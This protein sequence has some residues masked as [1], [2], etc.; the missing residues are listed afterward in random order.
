MTFTSL[1]VQLLLAVKWHLGLLEYELASAAMRGSLQRLQSQSI[2]GTGTLA[3]RPH[4]QSWCNWQLLDISLSFSLSFFI[5]SVS[6]LCQSFSLPPEEF[7]S[8]FLPILMC[9]LC[10]TY[11]TQKK[12]TFLMQI[13]VHLLVGLTNI[14][15]SAPGMK[16]KTPHV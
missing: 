11:L 3:P 6:V 16:N 4:L 2:R 9:W 15:H 5:S 14:I 10:L 12:F 1:S 8:Y 7:H 13:A